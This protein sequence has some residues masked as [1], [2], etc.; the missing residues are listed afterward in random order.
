MMDKQTYTP[1]DSVIKQGDHVQRYVKAGQVFPV[2][3][4]LMEDDTDKAL[5]VKWDGTAGKAVALS[6]C[7]AAGAASNERKAVLVSGIYRV[8]EMNWP[9]GLTDMQKRAA[10]QGTAISVND[11]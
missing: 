4:P 10:F 3:T 2:R 8:S 7:V 6:A 9:D 1:D 5:L 11:E